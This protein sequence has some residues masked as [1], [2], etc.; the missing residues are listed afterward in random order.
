METKRG[1]ASKLL[2]GKELSKSD[3]RSS[4]PARNF[5]SQTSDPPSRQGTFKVRPPILFPGKEFGPSWT[6]FLAGKEFDPK[7]TGFR[8]VTSSARSARSLRERLR[9]MGV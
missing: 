4:F 2:P 6:Q 9:R 8:G 3:L 1:K 5:Q 7:F